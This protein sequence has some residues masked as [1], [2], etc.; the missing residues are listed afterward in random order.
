MIHEQMK[1][2]PDTINPLS[3]VCANIWLCVCVRVCMCVCMCVRVCV[4]VCICRV[5]VCVSPIA[6]IR[7]L[8]VLPPRNLLK[9]SVYN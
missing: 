7:L 8:Q 5:C 1:W 9:K 6:Q 2:D 3:D 4:C